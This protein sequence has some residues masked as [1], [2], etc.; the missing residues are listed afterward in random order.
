VTTLAT[1]AGFTTPADLVAATGIPFSDQQLAAITAPLEPGLVVAGAGTGKTTVMAARVVWLVGTGQV[2]A[3]QVL[4]LTFTTK[5][6]AELS[7]R[8]QDLL[9]K[10]GLPGALGALGARGTRDA[11]GAPGTRDVPGAP[12]ALGTPHNSNAPDDSPDDS[13]DR[14][15]GDEGAEPTVLTYHAYAARLL[16]EHGLRIGFEPDTRLI[17]DA[18]RFQLAAQAVSRYDGA[19]DHLTTWLPTTVTGLLALD[20]ELS[21][22]LVEPADVLAFQR[23][24]APLWA[25]AKQTED[26]RK[27]LLGQ[28]KRVELLAFVDLYRRIKAERGVMDFSDQVAGAARLAERCVEVGAVERDRFRVVLLDEYQDTSVAQARLLRA[29]F[30]DGVD[31][32]GRG[33]P[34]TA[35]GDPCQA[36]YGWRGASVGNIEQFPSQFRPAGPGD[37]SGVAGEATRYPLTVN[38]RSDRR[39][40]QTANVVAKPLYAAFRG[41][42]PLAPTP[43]ADEGEVRLAVVE[44]FQ[45]ELDLLATEVPLAHDL[46]TPWSEI[47]VLARDNKSVAAMHDALVG[48]GVPVEVVGLAGLLQMPEVIEVVSTLEV[49]RDVTANPALLTLLAGPRWAIG[50]RDLA[51]LGQRARVLARSDRESTS[52]TAAGEPP[53]SSDIRASLLDAVAGVDTADLVSLAEAL[54]DPG[55]LGYSDEALAR[56]RLL[57]DEL[58][59]LRRHVGEPLLDLVRRVVDVTGLEVELASSSSAVAM[60]RRDNL[61]TFLDA[62]SAFA[63]VDADASLAGLLA[64]LEAED[65]YGQGLSLA[66]P[67]QA[68]SV[69]LLTAHR[70]KGL[71]WDVVFVPGVSRKVFPTGAGRL[72]WTVSPQVLPAPLRG[73]AADQPAVRERSNAGLA[74]YAKEC[75]EASVTEERRLA[76]VAMTRPR[77]TLVVSCHWWGPEQKLVR[78]PSVFA[79]DVREA[80]G[81]FGGTVEPDVAAP[82]GDAENPSN[83]Q[84]VA[85]PW[86]AQPAEDEVARRAAAAALVEQARELG[87]PAAREAAADEL[88]L[89]EQAVVRQWDLEAEALLAEARAVEVQEVAVP[90]PAALSATTLLRV[91]DDPSGLARQLARPMPRKPSP[92]ARFGTRFH[93]WVETHVGEPLLLDPDDLPGRADVDITGDDDLRALIEAFRAGP[94][95]DRP[96]LQIEAPF[97]LVLAGHVVRGRID[98]VY[99][100]EDGFEVVDWK[101]NQAKTADPLQLATYRLAWAE[102]TG[103]ELAKVTGSFYYVRTGDVVTYDDLPGRDELE[104]LLSGD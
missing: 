89:D 91:K 50:P 98:A 42:E 19:V 60:A 28:Q 41:A 45:D 6:A 43:A 15:L 85:V 16:V 76:Y 29:L 72:K 21:E 95:G 77:K 58:N 33:H 24:E 63:G 84:N 96:P 3:D 75:G 71:E 27:V 14:S 57:A 25:A 101:T 80:L 87:W 20:A 93:A 22:H 86:P 97:A 104:R 31:P 38:R 26:V 5:A 55:S 88:M 94:Y 51:L 7:R 17:S 62:V 54:A 79:D 39:I 40:L 10:A 59:G 30:S 65:E 103:V 73:D 67:T 100:T 32:G 44:T 102:L 48:A 66:L 82:A 56:F 52:R 9:A 4:G 8:I 11:P 12:G 46:G 83:R 69:K 49:L 70:A 68:D 35:V 36:I 61:A 47:A 78:G 99:A 1:R 81:A 53:P 34:V 23:R 90:L 13:P 18:T 2:A 74:A 92:A 64:Y 37:R